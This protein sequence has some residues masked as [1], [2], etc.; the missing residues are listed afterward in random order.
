MFLDED[1]EAAWQEIGPYLL[2]EA[3]E[4]GSWAREGVE[5]P[6]ASADLTLDKL[7]AEGRYEILTP[8]QCLRR[9]RAAHGEYTVIL[10]PMAGGIPLV[11]AWNCLQLYADKVLAP[12]GIGVHDSSGLPQ[13]A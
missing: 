3:A 1:P 11:R 2:A 12:L 4:Y 5:R 10:H 8:A 13:H 7:R 6:F 9:I